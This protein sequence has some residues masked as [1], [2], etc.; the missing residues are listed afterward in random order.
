M[1]STSPAQDDF[2]DAAFLSELEELANVGDTLEVEAAEVSADL[3]RL[4]EEFLVSGYTGSA[5]VFVP[6]GVRAKLAELEALLEGA[7]GPVPAANEA[8]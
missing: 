6:A 1:D 5:G 4:L 3:H 7:K 2:F 8:P